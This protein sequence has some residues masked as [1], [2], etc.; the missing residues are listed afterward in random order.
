MREGPSIYMYDGA[1]YAAT[2][3]QLHQAY[4][5]PRIAVDQYYYY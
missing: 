1:M 3:L 2:Y 4:C 5:A